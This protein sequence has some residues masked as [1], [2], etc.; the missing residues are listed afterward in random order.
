MVK[1]PDFGIRNQKFSGDWE[2]GMFRNFVHL[3]SLINVNHRIFPGSHQSFLW[4][5]LFF[6]FGEV[7]ALGDKL[8]THM[9]VGYIL[10]FCPLTYQKP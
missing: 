5:L 2:F 4:H 9:E 1:A 8:C 6:M 10:P 3:G 7:S